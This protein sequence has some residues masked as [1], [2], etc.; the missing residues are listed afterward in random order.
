MFNRTNTYW[1]KGEKL[2]EVM[3]TL[4]DLVWGKIIFESD[5]RTD[6]QVESGNNSRII[7]VL[8][9]ERKQSSWLTQI[10][11]LEKWRQRTETWIR[12]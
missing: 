8:S 9:C 4:Y 7:K 1:K 11:T 5:K 2:I 3:N 10:Y 6:E 12:W